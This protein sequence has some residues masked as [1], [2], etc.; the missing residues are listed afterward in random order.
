MKPLTSWQLAQ[1]AGRPGSVAV[2]AC[3]SA[4][5]EPQVAKAGRLPLGEPGSWHLAQATVA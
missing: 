1:S 4:W 3:A 5:H 2:P